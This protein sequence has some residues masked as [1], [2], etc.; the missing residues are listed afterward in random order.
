SAAPT[1]CRSVSGGDCVPEA[2]ALTGVEG[3]KLLFRPVTF[4]FCGKA[5]ENMRHV[6]SRNF[7]RPLKSACHRGPRHVGGADIGSGEAAGTD[8]VICFGM[9]PGAFSVVGNAN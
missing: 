5:R 6:L 7:D 1:F 2:L 9:K 3:N 4:K 8:K